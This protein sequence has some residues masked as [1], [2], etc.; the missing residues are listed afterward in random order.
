MAYPQTPAKIH[1]LLIKVLANPEIASDLEQFGVRRGFVQ[2]SMEAQADKIWHGVAARLEEVRLAEQSIAALESQNPTDIPNPRYLDR[3]ESAGGPAILLGILAIIAL[4]VYGFWKGWNHVRQHWVLESSAIGIVAISAALLLL[5][6]WRWELRVNRKRADVKAKLEEL[7]TPLREKLATALKQCDSA[8]ELAVLSEVR[9][10][11]ESRK[12]RRYG[13]QLPKTSRD[14]LAQVLNPEFEIL[15][16]ASQHVRKLIGT[17]QGASIGVSGPRGA[18]KTTLLWSLYQTGNSDPLSVFTS[19]PVQYEPREFVLHLFSSVCSRLIEKELGRR[20]SF[21]LAGS[22]QRRPSESRL[23][24]QLIRQVVRVLPSAA[25]VLLGLGSFLA[26]FKVFIERQIAGFAA[27]KSPV[28]LPYSLVQALNLNPGALIQWGLLA[29]GFVVLFGS[30]FIRLVASTEASERSFADPLV[31]QKPLVQ[32]AARQ[33]ANIQFQQSYTSGWSGSFKLPIALEAGVKSD[34]TWAERQQTMPDIV[35]TYRNFLDGIVASEGNAYKRILICIDEL[36]KLESDE[37]AQRFLNGI[38]S[39]FNQS[40]CYYFASV[41][42]NAMSNFERRGLPIRDAFDSSFDE[43][44]YVDY[45]DLASSR[46]LLSRRLL[47]VPHPYVCFWHV[48]AGGLPRD[49]IRVCRAL[50][51]SEETGDSLRSVCARVVYRDV[52]AK[53]R[54]MAVA[55]GRQATTPVAFLSLL[56][57][58]PIKTTVD[59]WNSISILEALVP[60]ADTD[61]P[62]PREALLFLYFSAMLVELFSKMDEP[63]WLKGED[64]GLFERLAAVR[65]T[66]ANNAVLAAEN[67]AAIRIIFGLGD[68]PS[69]ASLLRSNG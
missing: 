67:L 25:G 2:T 17:M 45:L 51:D 60:S 48:A 19:A 32:D 50:F 31:D 12:G 39:I 54:A 4:A 64:E 53:L 27:A 20:Q 58:P 14:G 13:E 7:L 22:N 61:S 24:T 52:E 65:R 47:N 21:S 46:R 23:P 57:A 28:P 18:G 1:E 15:T 40:N 62:A 26:Y 5:I 33:L 36:D 43:V 11:L 68:R 29:F 37:A 10:F 34:Q 38:K 6:H 30:P 44:V 55:A 66:L 9:E 42:E 56:S 59:L 3:L 16:P 69:E 49:L 35:D 41:S 63:L 8:A